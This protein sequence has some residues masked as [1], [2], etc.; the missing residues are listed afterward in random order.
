[1]ALTIS[2]CKYSARVAF[3]I[4]VIP[5]GVKTGTDLGRRLPKMANTSQKLKQ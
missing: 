3:R 1:M 5:D 4:L 2:Y